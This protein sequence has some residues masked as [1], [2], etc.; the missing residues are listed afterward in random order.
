MIHALYKGMTKQDEAQ[1]ILATNLITDARLLIGTSAAIGDRKVFLS[2]LLGPIA[3][4][5][6]SDIE[7]LRRLGLIELARA[8]FVQGMD[9]AMVAASQWDHPTGAQFHFLVV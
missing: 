8:D 2:A 1:Q 4:Q 7:E 3:G 9:S 6:M 5:D